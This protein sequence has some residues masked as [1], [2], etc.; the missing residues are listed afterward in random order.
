MQTFVQ[1]VQREE[2]ER[3]FEVHDYFPVLSEEPCF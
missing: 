1:G 2:E 3:S